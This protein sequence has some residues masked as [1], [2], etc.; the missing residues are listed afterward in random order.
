MEIIKKQINQMGIIKG[1][2]NKQNITLWKLIEYLINLQNIGKN[3]IEIARKKSANVNDIKPYLEEI[4]NITKEITKKVKKYD[5]T[6][7]KKT[8]V[9]VLNRKVEVLNRRTKRKEPL[10]CNV[11]LKNDEL[12]DIK[13]YWKIKHFCK[14]CMV[15]T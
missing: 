1:Q 7:L 4:Y 11:C 15:S 10:R 5:K 14:R 6:K 13:I 2:I 3:I 12:F 8:K 9:E